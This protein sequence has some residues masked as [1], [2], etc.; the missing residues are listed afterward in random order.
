M[1]LT[2]FRAQDTSQIFSTSRKTR[3]NT[4]FLERSAREAPKAPKTRPK[5]PHAYEK[6]C[7]DRRA[8]EARNA[9]KCFRGP[10][11]RTERFRVQI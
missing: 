3:E 4:V 6:I 9:R 7:I 1:F 2:I 5:A 8:R 11:T 10:H